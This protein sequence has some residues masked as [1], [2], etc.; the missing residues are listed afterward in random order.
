MRSEAFLYDREALTVPELTAAWYF[1]PGPDLYGR[2]TVGYLES[3]FGGVSAEVLWKPQ[4]SRLAL[5]AEINRVRQ[6]D[7]DQRFGFRDYEVTTGNVSAYYDLGRGYMA[8]LDV[9]RYLAG[10]VG[11]TVTLARE[12]ANGWR[13]AAFA[14]KTDVS[15]AEF[16]E[17]SFDKGIQITVPLDW[18][19][20]KPTR[21]KRSILLR[22][23]QR[24]GGARLD[25]SG[26][27]YETVRGAQAREIDATWARFWK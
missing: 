19:G 25:V 7:F 9:G 3:M 20:G 12:F 21:A 22:P 14:T 15:A 4:D 5:G 16:G 17:G 13:I 23:V 6:R 11:A 10:D 24:D 27:L 18:I 1:R 26:R 8:Q 2:V